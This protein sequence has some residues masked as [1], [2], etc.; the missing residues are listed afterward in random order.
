MHEQLSKNRVIIELDAKR[1]LALP[2]R[3][4]RTRES[5]AEYFLQE[6]PRVPQAPLGDEIPIVVV[7][8]A[9]GLES[10]QEIMQLIGS[11]SELMDLFVGSLEEPYTMGIFNQQQ[12]LTQETA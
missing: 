6:Q 7:L 4:V 9:M 12:A 11:E 3:V 1:M 8:K 2:S 5:L 10:D